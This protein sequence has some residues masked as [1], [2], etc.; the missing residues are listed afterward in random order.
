MSVY[1]PGAA[2]NGFDFLPDP[3]YDSQGRQPPPRQQQMIIMVG[4]PKSGKTTRARE[5]YQGHGYTR[6][7]PDDLRMALFGQRFL[8]TMERFVWATIEAMCRA[9]LYGGHSI[10]IDSTN[11]TIEGRKRWLLLAQESN[12]Q[13]TIEIMDT[14]IEQCLARNAQEEHVEEQVPPAVITEMVT[15][16]EQ[17]RLLDSPR[18][19]AIW[20]IVGERAIRLDGTS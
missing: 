3:L 10:V 5:K 6:I 2:G 7:C 15:S 4:L 16:F 1:V 19:I 14:P 11:L 8:A 12:T 20:S 18:I 9:L 17:P 13:V